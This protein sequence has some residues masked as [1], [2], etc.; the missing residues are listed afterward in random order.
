MKRI[1]PALAVLALTGCGASAE[2]A[3]TTENTSARLGTATSVDDVQSSYIRAGGTCTGELEDRGVVTVAAS[4]GHCPSSGTVLT[5]YIDYEDA[6]DAADGL[7]SMGDKIPVTL[8]LGENWM[9]NPAGDDKARADDIAKL[10][11]GQV[12]RS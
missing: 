7:L 1:I 11:G 2:P 9:V 3:E 8:I 5:A 10:M 12:I 6:K 4:S